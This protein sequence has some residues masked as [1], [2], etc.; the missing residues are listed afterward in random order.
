MLVLASTAA[1][2]MRTRGFDT[3]GRSS[4][5]LQ[6]TGTHHPF[7]GAHLFHFETLAGQGPRHEYG[8]AFVMAECVA[9]VNQF[10]GVKLKRHG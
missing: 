1:A 10:L 9:T 6:R 2:E 3:L 8:A 5:N 4:K 7:G